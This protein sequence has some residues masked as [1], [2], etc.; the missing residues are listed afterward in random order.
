MTTEQ[1][2][3]PSP[4]FGPVLNA[5]STSIV[6]TTLS[7]VAPSGNSTS[8]VGTLVRL[9]LSPRAIAS[10]TYGPISS[11]S[12][13]ELLNTSP[14]TTSMGG[15]ISAKPRTTVLF[16]VP[17]SPELVQG[18]GVV[19]HTLYPSIHLFPT[20]YQHPSNPRIDSIEKQR[21]LHL[22]L[23]NDCR[24]WVNQVLGGH[25]QHVIRAAHEGS[26]RSSG[27]RARHARSK[28]PSAS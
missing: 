25:L 9:S 6:P 15:I 8:G 22:L 1:V 20:C 24:K 28:T 21:Q 5:L 13:E 3:S 16:P 7:S 2:E 14:S 4:L 12:V 27:S 19:C 11:E 18:R 10:L 23:A 17:R 26:S